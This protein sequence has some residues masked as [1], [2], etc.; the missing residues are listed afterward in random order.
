MNNLWTFIDERN[1]SVRTKYTVI[2]LI[3][4]V[5][6]GLA[7]FLVWLVVRNWALSTPDWMLCLIGYPILASWYTVVFYSCGHEFR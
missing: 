6:F 4:G 1:W 2:L 5:L 7:G 3:L